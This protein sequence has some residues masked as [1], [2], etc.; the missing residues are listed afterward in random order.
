MLLTCVCLAVILHIIFPDK[1]GYIGFEIV[2]LV[3]KTQAITEK[4]YFLVVNVY[5]TP[6]TIQEFQ[7]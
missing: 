1:S 3:L 7:H 6:I 4:N 2:M 5:S